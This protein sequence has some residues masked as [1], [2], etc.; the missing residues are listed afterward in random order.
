[1]ISSRIT[2]L[3]G[4]IFASLLRLYRTPRNRSPLGESPLPVARW[5]EAYATDILGTVRRTKERGMREAQTVHWADVVT[6]DVYQPGLS[7]S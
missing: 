3:G 5:P 2:K 4:N 6:Q 7:T 1:M